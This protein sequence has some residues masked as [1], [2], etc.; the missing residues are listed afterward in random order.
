M[1]IL[2]GFQDYFRQI[3]RFQANARWFLLGG[4]LIGVGFSIFSLLFNL[5]LREAGFSEDLIGRILSLGSLGTFLAAL[6]AAYLAKRFPAQTILVVSSLL[7]A[8][9][10]LAQASFLQPE[11]LMGANLFVGGVLTVSRLLSAP[12]FMR[13]SSSSERAH[14]FA[15]N[16]AVGVLAGIL[17]NLLGGYL[18][19]L[20]QSFGLPHLTALQVSL[21]TGAVLA[22]TGLIPYG[23]IREKKEAGPSITVRQLF[24]AQDKRLIVKICIP[25]A[26][27]GMG[28]GLVIPFLNLY[29]RD[30]FGAS[31]GQIGVYF[32]FLQGMMVLGFLSG[33]V[34]AR[35]LGMINTIVLSQLASIPFMLILA[36][37]PS[38]PLALAA[39]LIRGTLMNMSGPIQSLFNME[40]VPAADREV[41]NSF[42]VLAWNG[43]WTIS[44]WVGGS[45]IHTLSFSISFY[46][47]IGFYI[48]SSLAY[49]FL[50]RRVERRI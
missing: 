16:M 9:G 31:P 1:I 19:T 21:G 47:T 3:Q 17:G 23:L 30:V 26:L 42:S 20:F 40:M 38:L 35:R 18:P 37:A 46:I 4:F 22:L 50:F 7:G 10:Y 43:A 28:A 27:V 36:L 12:F 8:F 32:A 2:Q 24:R 25:Y 15:F 41:T 5:T 14:L 6:P 45:I 48:L 29:F 49:Y 44:S 34:L 13:N 39:F 11:L 33:P